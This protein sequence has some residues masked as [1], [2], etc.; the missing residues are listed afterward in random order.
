MALR[1]RQALR[2]ALLGLLI[3]L[4]LALGGCVKLGTAPTRAPLPPPKPQAPPAPV[5]SEAYPVFDQLRQDLLRQEPALGKVNCVFAIGVDVSGS[6]HTSQVLEYTTKLLTDAGRYFFSPGDKVVVIPWDSRVREN[7][8]REFDVVSGDKAVSDLQAAFE[9]LENLVEPESRG[10]NLLDARGYCMEKALGYQDK[11]QGQLCGVVLVFT[12]IRTPDMAF[13]RQVYTPDKLRRLRSRLTGSDS[14]EFTVAAY[15]AGEK[16]Q[17]ILHSLVGKAQQTTAAQ[18]VNRTRSAPAATRPVSTP[19]PPPPPDTSG[20]RALLI[21]VAL[22]CL[23][24]MVALPF[25]WRHRLAIGDVRESVRALGGRFKVLAGQGISP[26]GAVYVRAPGLEGQT[27]VTLEGRGP[28]LVAIARSGVRLNDGR[29][30]V[31]IPLGRPC[32]L[33][34]SIDGVPGEQVLEVQTQEF[35]A[36]NTGPILGMAIAFLVVVACIIG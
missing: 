1:S 9:G 15:Q 2:T 35:F 24:A 32:S 33:R 23:L 26:R 8:V 4:S 21:V 36:S 18:S 17:I 3:A 28:Q 6:S 27:L 11:S 20:A 7:Q 25:T 31:A 22:V 29:S 14:S 13:S 5:R 16:T 30:E 12:D 10:S 34:L 19:P